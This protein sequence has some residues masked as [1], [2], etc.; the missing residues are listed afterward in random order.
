MGSYLF[1]KEAMLGIF[2]DILVMKAIFIL[3]EVWTTYNF[4]YCNQEKLKIEGNI[5]N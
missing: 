3:S 1:W 5:G 4:F 2:V